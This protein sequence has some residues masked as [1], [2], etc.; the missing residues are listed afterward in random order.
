[1]RRRQAMSAQP[2]AFSINTIKLPARAPERPVRA[3]Q[4]VPVAPVG[5]D[6]SALSDS[7]LSDCYLV[8]FGKRPH[9]RM[10]RETIERRI[11]D[12]DSR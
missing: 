1:M 8:K 4:A 3:V 2:D 11:I 5:A 12:D 10:K 6:Y 7:A 9:H